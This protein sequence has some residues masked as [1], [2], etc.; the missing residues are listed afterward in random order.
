MELNITQG[1]SSYDN[2]P[3]NA[4]GNAYPPENPSEAEREDHALSEEDPNGGRMFREPA[5]HDDPWNTPQGGFAPGGA[6]GAYDRE[7]NP[8]PSESDPAGQPAYGASVPGAAPSSSQM[9][10]Q[11][12][13]RPYYGTPNNVPPA[14]SYQ[15]PPQ[16]IGG[17]GYGGTVGPVSGQVYGGGPSA[18]PV[19]TPEKKKTGTPLKIVITVA[20]ITVA[21]LVGTTLGGV[22]LK[23]WQGEDQ[24]KEGR[25]SESVTSSSDLFDNS[26]PV[27]VDSLTI[28]LPE[29]Y[30]E[31]IDETDDFE[32]SYYSED[33]GVLF[34]LDHS[35]EEENEVY[36]LEEYA[37]AVCEAFEMG[38]LRK[39]A[40]GTM[41]S[42]YEEKINGDDF[43]FLVA[44]Y[45]TGS[46]QFWQVTFFC[47]SGDYGDLRGDFLEYASSVSITRRG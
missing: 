11:Q 7:D 21:T 40:N 46:N 12:G 44:F 33:A 34:S 22:I 23:G 36:S 26:R 28:Y 25:S 35:L 16:M 6:Y 2:D 19:H 3:A 42:E 47:Y 37:E 27:T 9:P 10:T 45:Q 20:V 41:Y 38:P 24:K 15:P 29:E 32:A 8:T 17:S 43:S 14:V 39:T 30:E 31:E 4:Q 18:V 1:R 13:S 5:V